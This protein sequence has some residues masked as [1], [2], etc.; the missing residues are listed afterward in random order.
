MFACTGFRYALLKNLDLA[1]GV[2]WQDHNDYLAAPA[3]CTGSGTA[4]S[5]RKCAGGRYSY[6]FMFNY[7]PV[8]RVTLYMGLMVSTVYGGVASGF[9]HSQNI[10]P[11]IG[12][13]YQF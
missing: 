5:S 10:D 13:R 11:T 2:Y 12:L 8:P 6:S 3:V 1:T 4:T 7:K 9:L